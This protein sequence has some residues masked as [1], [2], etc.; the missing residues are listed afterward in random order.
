MLAMNNEKVKSR[1]QF[2]HNSSKE[3]KILR[4][5]FNGRDV[6]LVQRKL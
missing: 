6:R 5:K 2:L 4:N 1:K 3:N